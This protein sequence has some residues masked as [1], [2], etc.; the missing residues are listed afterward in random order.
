MTSSMTIEEAVSYIKANTCLIDFLRG[1]HQSPGDPSLQIRKAL[2][3]REFILLEGF[4]YDAPMAR[5]QLFISADTWDIREMIQAFEKAVSVPSTER[6]ILER[7]LIRKA[8]IKR[9]RTYKKKP[10]DANSVPPV[11]VGKQIAPLEQL[12]LK[13]GEGI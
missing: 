2:N 3:N 12:N 4:S 11:V 8:P 1:S 6:G 7:D 9:K 13:L 5:V 10:W